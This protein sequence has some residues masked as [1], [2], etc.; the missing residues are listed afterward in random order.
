MSEN[1]TSYAAPDG[2]AGSKIRVTQAVERFEYAG[3]FRCLYHSYVRRGLIQPGPQSM[4]LTRHHLLPTT[5][6]LVARIGRRV[7]GTL[8][9]AEDGPL[10]VPLR[11]VFNDEV[12]ELGSGD[13]R[14]AEATC[15]A[16]DH[17]QT[18]GVD[19]LH[20]LMGLA[21]QLA[22]R[23]GTSQILIAVHPR[24]AR[25]Y[26]RSAGFRQFTSVRSYPSV[27]GRPAVGL[28]LN[29]RRLH[30]DFPCV[31]R[32]YFGMSFSPVGL[33][34]QA[35]PRYQLEWLAATWLDIH[36]AVH[37]AS[38]TPRESLARPAA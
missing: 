37:N 29:L 9:L 11:C 1:F 31:Y 38:E 15:L 5:R 12:N 35:A 10:G 20:Q 2:A 13:A 17:S 33:C 4:R 27:G 32:R 7:V 14:L 8:S 25:F 30:V 3:A 21:A 34:T 26:T 24:H 22:V 36:G 16:L 6:V 28:A 23:C 19:L 18:S